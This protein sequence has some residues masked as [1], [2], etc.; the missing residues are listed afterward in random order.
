[1]LNFEHFFTLDDLSKEITRLWGR[2]QALA[3]LLDELDSSVLD[4]DDLAERERISRINFGY[5]YFLMECYSI[6]ED[7]NDLADIDPVLMDTIKKFSFLIDTLCDESVQ[8]LNWSM[9]EQRSEHPRP[10][11]YARG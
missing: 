3:K 4:A 7:V 10:V 1:M 6:I 9:R 8:A 2:Q 11:L 5:T